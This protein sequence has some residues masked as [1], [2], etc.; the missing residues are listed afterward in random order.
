L[1][2]V[3]AKKM[4]D[5]GVHQRGAALA[6]ISIHVCTVI[7][8]QADDGEITVAS[9]SDRERRSQ[10]VGNRVDLGAMVE[11]YQNLGRGLWQTPILIAGV[12]ILLL[13]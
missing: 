6:V 12:R 10:V 2:H 13:P 5:S 7:E 11:Q 1:D 9:R 8:K 3:G 4:R